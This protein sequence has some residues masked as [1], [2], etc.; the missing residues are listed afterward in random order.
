MAL[1]MQKA[2]A[3]TTKR[4]PKLATPSIWNPKQG[5]SYIELH[6]TNQT[7]E[8]V[9]FAAQDNRKYIKIEANRP[10]SALSP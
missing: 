2:Q 8:K 5:P 6:E 7:L 9:T 10:P 1:F 3:N 4:N